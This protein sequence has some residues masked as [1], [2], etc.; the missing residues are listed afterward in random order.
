VRRAG[1]SKYRAVRTTL[2]GITYA[3]KL[4]ARR[5]GELAMLEREGVITG[6]RRQVPFDIV[7]NGHQICRYVA[8]FCYTAM[9]SGESVCEDVKGVLTPEFKLKAK[10]LEAT[11]GIVIQ[12]W[13]GKPTWV[14]D[15]NKGRWLRKTPRPASPKTSMRGAGSPKRS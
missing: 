14:L 10:L 7:V 5:A 11:A 4:E 8:D 1:W 15:V 13:T 12:V 9:D 6:L 3:S 2:D